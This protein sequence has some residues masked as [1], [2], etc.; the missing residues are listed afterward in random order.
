[1]TFNQHLRPALF[2]GS[3]LAL[4]ACD[5]DK[6]VGDLKDGD[7]GN[8]TCEAP[9]RTCPDGT[10]VAPEPPLCET[11]VCPGEGGDEGGGEC[12]ADAMI[13]PD[14]SSVGRRG[15]DCAFAPCPEPD[16]VCLPEECGPMP[17]VPTVE[18]PNG[19]TAGPVCERSGQ[20]TCAWSVRSCDDIGCTGEARLCADG[21]AVGRVPPTC[22]FEACPGE[23]DPADCDPMPPI[24]I[25]NILCDDGTYAGA[26]CMQD[27]AGGCGWEIRECSWSCPDDAKVCPDG[28]TVIRS[29]PDCEFAPCPTLC[30][31]EAVHLTPAACPSTDVPILPGPGCYVPCTEEGTACES[32]GT[33]MLVQTN[34]CECAQGQACCAA[35][36]Q[37]QTVC[38]TDGAITACTELAHRTFE[39]L[40]QKECGNSPDGEALCRWRISF[41]ADEYTW[42]HSD[43]AENGPYT[44]GDGRIV[45]GGYTGEF[46]P[47]TGL[48]V[49]DD[50]EYRAIE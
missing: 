14:G 9:A 38:V 28:T 19:G 18:C 31:G 3:L 15:P 49:W 13:C 27:A 21:S 25:P 6:S 41:N 32:G 7:T 42:F 47:Q 24:Y 1:M 11:P 29:G 36:G 23:C 48:L 40:E 45:A 17:D 50:V 33:C 39:S 46:D 4:A 10:V 35:C 44:C 43:V 30:E 34:P 5:F 37:Q 20:D 8:A 2:L 16:P 12:P 26:F 22:E